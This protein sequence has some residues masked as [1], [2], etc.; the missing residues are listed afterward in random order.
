MDEEDSDDIAKNGIAFQEA[1]LRI[2][3]SRAIDEK[4]KIISLKLSNLL[5]LQLYQ[6]KECQRVESPQILSSIAK[7]IPN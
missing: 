4:A 5:I 1:K 2:L 7:Q 6:H 3:P